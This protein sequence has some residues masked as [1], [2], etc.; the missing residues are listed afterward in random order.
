MRSFVW[1]REGSAGPSQRTKYA[2]KF[3]DNFA[4]V[5]WVL[6]RPM[7]HQNY[8]NFV[9][10]CSVGSVGF[11]RNSCIVRRYDNSKDDGS[12]Y[13]CNHCS[14][15]WGG[16][17]VHLPVAL[18]IPCKQKWDIF[19]NW[20]FRGCFTFA[21]AHSHWESRINFAGNKKGM[22]LLELFCGTKSIGKANEDQGW[23]VVS[24]D[25]NRKTNQTIYTDIMDSDYN[26]LYSP[27]YFAHVH[28]SPP[29]KEF[30]RAKTVGTRKLWLADTIAKRT[31]EMIQYFSSATYSIENPALGFFA[32]RTIGILDD[33]PEPHL[34][35]YYKF[36]PDDHTYRKPTNIWTNLQV[37]FP[38][39]CQKGHR[40][41]Y[42]NGTRHPNNAQRGSRGGIP[43]NTRDKLYSMPPTI[44]LF[45][46]SSLKWEY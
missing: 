19:R 3:H 25:A 30:S 12:D 5:L 45:I 28:A 44:I 15:L 26:K 34:V 16:S 31:L 2:R 9:P 14:N 46:P 11:W 38:I 27:N 4:Q 10:R 6:P 23:D 13:S 41:T 1:H 42:F 29:C 37:E 36:D 32:L 35:S 7:P 22:R 33:F 21:L 40:C 20:L 39:I 24:V 18:Q 43:G 17:C 8:G